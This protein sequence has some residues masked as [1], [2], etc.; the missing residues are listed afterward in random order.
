MNATL[1]YGAPLS[2][3]ITTGNIREMVM[4][5][6]GGCDAAVQTEIRQCVTAVVRAAAIP[7]HTGFDPIRYALYILYLQ[8]TCDDSPAASALL[9]EIDGSPVP[10]AN[11]RQYGASN[12][13]YARVHTH[14]MSQCMVP[15]AE[16]RRIHNLCAAIDTAAVRL[17]NAWLRQL[18]AVAVQA[19]GTEN[20]V[21]SLYQACIV[22]ACG[23]TLALHVPD[24]ASVYTR[25]KVAASMYGQQPA[26]MSITG[27]K[28]LAD[29]MEWAGR[30]AKTDTCIKRA[31]DGA[32]VD[33]YATAVLLHMI[34]RHNLQSVP[35]RDIH[36][37]AG[38]FNVWR[39]LC[40]LTNHPGTPYILTWV[41]STHIGVH[42]TADKISTQSVM[43][44]HAEC[45]TLLQLVLMHYNE[46]NI[47]SHV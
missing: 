14:V 27:V 20:S 28:T 7:S 39:T 34:F 13:L 22:D 17:D 47:M 3:L 2:T 40:M 26:S 25:A 36:L 23:F 30:Y 5:V 11:V 43:V 12:D 16:L 8:T 1:T 33:P 37:A 21:A 10:V 24:A 9:G 6:A 18:R 15:A 19:Y 42:T 29:V 4:L 46:I 35:T 31:T 38:D 45:R 44:R 32:V 41:T